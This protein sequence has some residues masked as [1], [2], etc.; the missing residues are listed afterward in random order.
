MNVYIYEHIFFLSQFWYDV[1]F[2]NLFIH[3]QILIFLMHKVIHRIVLFLKICGVDN[4]FLITNIDAL[5]YLS[6]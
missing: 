6:S 3:L 4:P 1:L 5:H 2:G